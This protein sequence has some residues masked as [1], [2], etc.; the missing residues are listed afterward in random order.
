MPTLRSG[1]NIGVDGIKAL[2][3]ALKVNAAVT[4]I[5]TNGERAVFC[6]LFVFFFLSSSFF[7]F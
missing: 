7:F 1:A 6:N 2:A 5:D 3:A 4:R